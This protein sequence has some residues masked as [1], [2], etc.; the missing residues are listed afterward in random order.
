MTGG[1][2]VHKFTRTPAIIER[3]ILSD[4]TAIPGIVKYFRAKI[5]S[6]GILRYHHVTTEGGLTHPLPFLL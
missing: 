4:G 2:I 5:E 3:K 1:F 6:V